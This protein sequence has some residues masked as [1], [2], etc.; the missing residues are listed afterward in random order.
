[1]SPVSRLLFTLLLAC[2]WS[3]S[4]LFIKLAV[5]EIP[6]LTVVAV[7]VSLA[8]LL[9]LVILLATGNRF[10]KDSRFWLHTTFMAILSSVLPFFFFCYAEQSIDSALAALINGASPTCTAL[11]AHL[12]LPSDRITVQKASGI[13]L[14]TFGIVFLFAPALLTG[15]SGTTVGMLAAMG[16]TLS[17][18]ASHVYAKKFASGYPALVAPT[19]QLLISGALVLPFALLIDQPYLLPMPSWSALLGVAGLTLMG[20]TLAFI[21]YYR[22]LEH[23]GAT[24]ISMVACVFPITAMLLGFLFLGETFSAR[25]L[26]AALFILLGMMFVN[27]IITYDISTLW[28]SRRLGTPALEGSNA[29]S[30]E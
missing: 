9:L 4:F 10:P 14:S 28:R 23:A 19:A 5:H 29:P 26:V 20:T 1:M 13:A 11:I 8:A 25:G 6:P 15:L 21:V 2:M 27:G 24:A 7:R 18:G 16:G 30:G 3:P 12:L 17:Y 22:L